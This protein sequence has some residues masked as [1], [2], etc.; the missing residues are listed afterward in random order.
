MDEHQ[1]DLVLVSETEIDDNMLD[2]EV[3][4]DGYR[5]A[6]KPKKRTDRGIMIIY[7]D[8]LILSEINLINTN[9]ELVIVRL[10][11]FLTTHKCRYFRHAGSKRKPRAHHQHS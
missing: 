7:K 4:P 2:S 9:C 1:P 8:E 3:L 10:Q 6:R 5:S 11:I